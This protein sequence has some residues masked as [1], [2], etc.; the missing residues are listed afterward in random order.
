[1]PE[2]AVNKLTHK[3]ELITDNHQRLLLEASKVIAEADSLNEGLKLLTEKTIHYI[4]TTFC[5]FLLLNP[6]TNQFQLIASSSTNRAVQ[7]VWE[8][9]PLRH[10]L[11]HCS[12]EI[13][14]IIEEGSPVICHSGE[15]NK[16]LL[17]CFQCTINI[18]KQLETALV[19]PLKVGNRALGIFIM[20]EMRTW[21]RKPFTNNEINLASTLANQ[22]A[23]LIEKIRL[24]E[25]SINRLNQI[26]Q[27]N[28]LLFALD[29]ASRQIRAV[30]HASKLPHEISGNAVRLVSRR[31]GCYLLYH[32]SLKQFEVTAVTNLSDKLINTRIDSQTSW[33]NKMCQNGVATCIPDENSVECSDAFI[34]KNHFSSGIAVPIKNSGELEA[35]ILVGNETKPP[36]KKDE[37]DVLERFAAQATLAL[38]TSKLIN[39]EQR[40]YEQFSV[41]KRISE[42]IQQSNDLEKILHVVLTGVT[43]GYGLGFNRAILFLRDEENNQLIGK[44]GIGHKSKKEAEDDWRKHHKNRLE[45]FEEY[46]SWLDKGKL[47]PSTIQEKIIKLRIPILE[48]GE[49]AFSN[50]ILHQRSKRIDENEFSLLPQEFIKAFHSVSTTIIVPL[51]AHK[52]AIGLLVVDNKFTHTPI[53]DVTINTLHT[54]ANTAAIAF[55]RTKHIQKIE[56]E[57]HDRNVLLRISRDLSTKKEIDQ[58]LS[59]LLEG[60]I[61]LLKVEM[62]VAHLINENTG[63]Y[64]SYYAP[65]ELKELFVQP[66]KEFGLT[67]III[68]NNEPLIIPDTSKNNQVNP[69]S[70]ELG[71]Q[72]MVGFPLQVRGKIIGVL[73]FNSRRMQ[74]FQERELELIS[75]LIAQGAVAMENARAFQN[76]EQNAVL[77]NALVQISQDLAENQNSDSQLEIIWQFVKQH[78]HAPMF[79]IGFSNADNNEIHYKIAYDAYKK[80]SPFSQKINQQESLG[81]AG[82]VLTTGKMLQ[83]HTKE[84]KDALVSNQKIHLRIKGDECSSSIICPLQVGKEI[85]GV[86]AMQHHAA[87]AWEE[88]ELAAFQ[89]LAQLVAV[90]M[91]NSNLMSEINEG[92]SRLEAAY[93]ASQ[94]I[95]TNQD[96]DQTLK[97]IVQRVCNV[98]DAWRAKVILIDQAGNPQNIASYGY[99]EEAERATAVRPNGIS[100][101]VVHSKKA[102][103]IENLAITSFEYN[104]AMLEQGVLAASCI[105]LEYR[106]TCLG[107][108]WVD[109]DTTRRF[110]ENDK[111]TLQLYANQAAIAYENARQI[112]ELS[113]MRQ[114]AEALSSTLS[115]TDTLNQI[116]KSARNVLR[117]ESAAIW[118]Y[119]NQRSRFLLTESVASGIPEDSWNYY[120]KEELETGQTAHT[121]LTSRDGWIGVEDVNDHERYPFLGLSSRKLLNA[122]KVQSFQGIRLVVGDEVLGILYVNHNQKRCFESEEEKNT[123]RIFANHAAMAL[124]NARLIAQLSAARETASVVAGL[125]VLG[126]IEQTLESI[127]VGTKKAIDCDIVTLFSYNHEQ[128]QFE[129]PPKM[130]GVTDKDHIIKAGNINRDAVPYKLIKLEDYYKTEDTINDKIMG[131]PFAKREGIKSSAGFPLVVMKQRVGVMCVNYKHIH[132]F[133]DDELESIRIF[134]HQAGIAI[135]NAQLYNRLQQRANAL[136]ALNEAGKMITRS[137]EL[138]TILDSIAEQAWMLTGKK[139]QHAVSASI[140]MSDDGKAKFKAGFPHKEFTQIESNFLKGIDLNKGINGKIGVIGMAIKTGNSQLI[141]DVKTTPHYLELNSLTNSELAVPIKFGDRIIGAINVEHY[142]MNVFD[143]EDQR[144]LESLAAYAGIA[145]E[146]ATQYEYLKKIKGFIGNKTATEWI[147][148]VSQS[149]GHSIRGDTAAALLRIESLRRY[150]T[151]NKI[152]IETEDIK[153]IETIIKE[154]QNTPIVAPLTIEDANSDVEINHLLSTYMERKFKQKPHCYIEVCYDLQPNLDNL[155]TVRA[156]E[157]WLRRAIEILVDNA[158]QAMMMADS[159]EKH[160]TARTRLEGDKIIIS[161]VD[162]GPGI[163]DEMVDFIGKEPVKSIKG[164]GVG[165]TLANNFIQTYGGELMLQKTGTNGT[166]M[167]ILL[168]AKHREI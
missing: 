29:E 157:E 39:R 56:G 90:S 162:K 9:T 152:E 86:I 71:I 40:I 74:Y 136:D 105:P 75:L 30:E 95:T 59:T 25:L 5:C 50:V 77:R 109:Y 16:C 52:H 131:G 128:D 102:I 37:I 97:D 64:S 137:L 62:A 66:R 168:P 3:I 69:D 149:W 101:E 148:M 33:L 45:G 93:S 132:H 154:I 104:P 140:L 166:E 14:S 160:L 142:L 70:M 19:V 21:N 143:K 121:I 114:A 23:T 58:V 65:S 55:E 83:W 51:V 100:Y 53:P 49:D 63:E 11:P 145:I 73:F 138:N 34:K 133:N 161:I 80:L 54:F 36:F 98:M 24:Y 167:A 156:S 99:A 81:A 22:V 82:Y 164:A 2:Q 165:L 8:P 115:L 158:V 96:P 127:V 123:A 117:A 107:V 35:V 47:S 103:Y 163:P 139:G 112:R 44:L 119:D 116:A 87:H 57:S 10:C 27:R 12:A 7:F 159:P 141:S 94:D 120:R 46:L 124:K 150:L 60:G 6:E 15:Q 146:H 26:D 111:K 1:M 32:E 68:R 88:V 72:S 28:Q 67:S 135:Y 84:E 110:T 106:N 134:A 125:T 38:Q 129:F 155:V 89:T 118:S 4:E 61:Q 31:T 151:K 91:K 147:R 144:D 85:N 108:L 130:A 13:W 43:A 76:L 113:H 18:P 79:Y 153:E 78:L 17:D 92:K 122:L 48:N 20:G 41:L 42:Y 126:E